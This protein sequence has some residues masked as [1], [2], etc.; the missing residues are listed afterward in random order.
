MNKAGKPINTPSDE[1][2]FR[3]IESEKVGV[4]QGLFRSKV[5]S[6]MYIAKRTRPDIL[7]E[8]TFLS[9]KCMKATKAD[10][11]KLN[12]V[13]RYLAWNDEIKLYI[14]RKVDKDI[15]LE[16]FCDA[17]HMIHADCK[18]QTGALILFNGNF[19]LGISKKQSINADSSCEAELIALH[20]GSHMAA[21]L[22]NIL[23][24]L[25]MP[26]SKQITIFQDNQATIK[27]ANQGHGKFG[28][29][30]HIKRRYFTIK[31]LIDKGAIKLEFVPTGD[32]LADFFTKPLTVAKRRQLRAIMMG[33]APEKK[34][35]INRFINM[36]ARY[37]VNGN[38]D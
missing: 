26:K 38:S 7:L 8:V 11:E 3:D 29:T 2:F 6:L 24:E 28:R 36:L 33:K 20:T 34:T 23:D 5:M 21:W 30:K 4:D 16:I 9:T 1:D 35:E 31:D 27:L 12:R 25:G 10:E 32:M 17:S 15:T 22:D 13:M 14:T 37:T 18:G 19:V